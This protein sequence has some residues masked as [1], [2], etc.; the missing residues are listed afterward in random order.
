VAEVYN[1]EYELEEKLA[2]KSG[3]HE[4]KVKAL[5]SNATNYSDSDFSE[6]LS[7]EPPEYIFEFEPEPSPSRSRAVGDSLAIS[8]LTDFG[9]GLNNVVIPVSI[10]GGTVRSILANAFVSNANMQSLTI[11]ATITKIE[12]GAFVECSVLATITFAAPEEGSEI[13]PVENIDIEDGAFDESLP[14]EV[15]VVVPDGSDTILKD[16]IVASIPGVDPE[17]IKE[18]AAVKKVIAVSLSE[19]ALTL[20]IGGTADLTATID[21]EDEDNKNVTWRSN[22][23]NVATV[24]VGEDGVVTVKAIASGTATITVTTVD[25]GFIDTCNITVNKPAANPEALIEAAF[26]ALENENYDAALSNF[27]AAYDADGDN[28]EAIVY[29]ALAKLAAISIDPKVAELLED[30]LG[31]KNYPQTMNALLDPSWLEEYKGTTYVDNYQIEESEYGSYVKVTGNLT[32]MYGS[33][34]VVDYW[35]ALATEYGDSLDWVWYN[36]YEE[37]FSDR[38]YGGYIEVTGFFDNGEYLVEYNRVQNNPNL[39]ANVKRYDVNFEE[40]ALIIDENQSSALFPELAVPEWFEDSDMYTGSLV[41]GL[42][43]TDTLMNLLLAN[44][45]EGNTAGLNGLIDGILDSVFGASF[46]EAAARIAKLDINERIVISEELIEGLNL[47]F[48]LEEGFKA[49]I[50]RAELQALTSA[51]RLIKGMLQ[52]IASYNLNSDLSFMKFDWNDIDS[53]DEI[54][55]RIESKNDPFANGFLNDRNNGSM[56]ESKASFVKALTDIAASYDY[57]VS[58]ENE[59]YP[60]GI[61]VEMKEYASFY[62]DG[63]GKMIQAIN[64]GSMFYV[65][66]DALEDMTGSW[67]TASGDISIDMGQFFTAGLFTLDKLIEIDNKKPVLYIRDQ[68]TGAERKMIAADVTA[69]EDLYD[70]MIAAEEAA[71]AFWE[72]EGQ[73]VQDAMNEASMIGDWTEYNRLSE[74]LST[75]RDEWNSLL[76]EADQLEDEYYDITVGMM[77]QTDPLTSVVTIAGEEKPPTKMIINMGAEVAVALYNHYWK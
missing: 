11:A 47:G 5:A 7:V 10:G 51:L 53:F 57:L 33:E 74:E 24:T 39:P 2:S 50:G 54:L 19:T 15:A 30:R 45:L 26:T 48:I 76:D 62:F 34:N 22:N 46:E 14:D 71:D 43:T 41:G 38:Y 23:T 40:E 61:K 70:N 17:D 35:Y 21:P 77:F 36:E 8:G 16:E 63:V 28:N 20:D 64:S 60:D 65:S 25:G 56:A 32:S 12:A 68:S 66:Y 52:W 75:I 44:A 4:V 49:E 9:K 69:I 72:E 31:L 29:S 37:Y 67:P 55:T 1:T 42:Q 18:E 59:S 3:E 27:E 13:P 6:P 73:P 58:D